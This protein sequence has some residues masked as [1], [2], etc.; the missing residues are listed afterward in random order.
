MVHFSSHVSF[1]F[2]SEDLR[3]NF[4]GSMSEEQGHWAVWPPAP[5]SWRQ[6]AAA[7]KGGRWFSAP[8]LLQVCSCSWREPQA[9]GPGAALGSRIASTET[10]RAEQL[11]GDF[12]MQVACRQKKQNHKTPSGSLV[13]LSHLDTGGERKEKQ[14][15][16]NRTG[17]G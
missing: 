12:G 14:Q 8:G 6:G 5:I 9:Q 10:E 1:L 3:L 17:R 16:D 11:Q 2:G 13:S 15:R 7:G 4:P